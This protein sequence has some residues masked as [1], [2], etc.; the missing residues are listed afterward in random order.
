M[1][2]AETSDRIFGQLVIIP[3]NLQALEFKKTLF[4]VIFWN[5]LTMFWAHII[6]VTILKEVVVSASNDRSRGIFLWLKNFLESPEVVPFTFLKFFWI[7]FFEIKIC[8]HIEMYFFA[9]QK[10]FTAWIEHIFTMEVVKPWKK[11]DTLSTWL[12]CWTYYMGTIKQND[13][14]GKINIAF[15]WKK[16][17]EWRIL[18]KKTK[19][20]EVKFSFLK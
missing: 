2:Q 3:A 17:P 6:T 20:L 1:G 15:V 10:A 19:K 11:N 14:F 7:S 8:I 13:V 16:Y 12:F 5:K 9:I 18:K 4:G